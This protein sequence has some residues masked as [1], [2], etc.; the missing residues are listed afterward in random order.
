MLAPP[1]HGSC[2]Y[3]AK[4]VHGE[5]E[6]ALARKR[7][8]LYEGDAAGAWKDLRD[9]G[10]DGAAVIAEWLAAGAPNVSEGHRRHAGEHLFRCGTPEHVR[11]AAQQ[12]DWSDA[13][14][15]TEMLRALRGR[16]PRFTPIQAE[17]LATAPDQGLQIEAVKAL[18]GAFKVQKRV[19][20]G[21]FF[22]GWNKTVEVKASRSAPPEHH[23]A[24]LRS[25]LDRN[26]VDVVWHPAV[27]AIGTLYSFEIPDQ[28][29]WFPVLLDAVREI[30]LDGDGKV[31]EAA[32]LFIARGLPS[33]LLEGAK[34][35]MATDRTG[36]HINFVAG[37]EDCIQDGRTHPDMEEALELFAKDGL[38]TSRLEAR[39]LL[40][41]G[42]R[43]R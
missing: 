43:R 25:V 37:L 31:S 18:I 38:G 20:I 35:A 14:E 2:E 12:V 36:V 23:V 21:L 13:S 22:M 1:W 4:A 34:A 6:E 28:D 41:I 32:A 7:G 16:V 39:F 26:R 17:H 11:V 29:A 42:G 5:H 40:T 10:P 15:V 19:G 27:K 33:D 9:Y 8:H 3:Q 24:A 30:D